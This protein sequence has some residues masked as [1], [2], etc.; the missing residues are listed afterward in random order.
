MPGSTSA[1]TSTLIVD[2][3]TGARGHRHDVGIDDHVVGT[4]NVAFVSQQIAAPHRDA[5]Q[6]VGSAVVQPHLGR[7]GARGRR[8]QIQR[9]RR[10]RVAQIEGDLACVTRDAARR[11]RPEQEL[12]GHRPPRPG[13]PLEIG[14]RH[15]ICPV[16]VHRC[17]RRFDRCGPVVVGFDGPDKPVND[18]TGCTEPLG[19]DGAQRSGV[20][21]GIEHRRPRQIVDGAVIAG[22]TTGQWPS[23]YFLSKLKTG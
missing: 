12:A 21:R 14:H 7:G 3:A 11:H 5:A 18:A 15:R 17:A 4:D 19:L 1:L 23:P 16:S 6:I 20:G 22:P 9:A 2:P 10:I 8:V 13:Q